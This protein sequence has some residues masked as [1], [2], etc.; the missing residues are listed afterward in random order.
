[1][2]AAN[3]QQL[4]SVGLGESVSLLPRVDCLDLDVV[5]VAYRSARHLRAC[6]EPLAHAA[7]MRVIVVDNDCPEASTS[8]VAD[9]PVTIVKMGR[10]AGFGAGCNAGSARGRGDAILFLNPDARIAPDDARHLAHRLEND[11]ALGACGPRIVDADGH[12]SPTI[13]RFPR[14]SSTLAEAFFVHHLL[15]DAIWANEMV[16]RGYDQASRVEWLSGAALCVRRSAFEAVGGFDERFFL[17]CEDTELCFQLHRAGFEV[18]YEAGAHAIHAGGASA[19]SA[20]QASLKA[21]ARMTYASIHG[22]PLSR[23]AFK[24]A[25]SFYELFRLPI[26]LVRSPAH[27]RGRAAALVTTVGFSA[28]GKPDETPAG[29]AAYPRHN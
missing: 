4:L 25:N 15:P 14:L 28:P 18:S 10:N 21:S 27:V 9:L 26:A 17:Y 23:A 29:R 3:G 16:R 5:V 24:V 20:G 2:T 12:T 13:R 11:P 22:G 7:G 1:M 8:T 6:V 19:P